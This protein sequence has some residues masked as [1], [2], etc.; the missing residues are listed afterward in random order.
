MLV[1]GSEH[2][3]PCLEAGTAFGADILDNALLYICL[4]ILTKCSIIKHDIGLKDMILDFADADTAQVFAERRP[5]KLPSDI[6]T[7]A[8]TKL[9]LLDA[10]ARLEDL[11]VPPGNRLEALSGN[12]AGQHSIRINDQWR[13]CFVWQ[14]ANE[15]QGIVPGARRVAIV[16]YH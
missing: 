14:Q 15:E 10:A 13:V 3:S 2:Y 6:L 16:D 5:K 8:L 9:R 11:R 4:T 12:R 1:Q 7:R